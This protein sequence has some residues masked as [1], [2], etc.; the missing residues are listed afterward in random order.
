MARDKSKDDTLFNCAQQYEHDYVVGL[1]NLGQR[2]FVRTFL[3]N[4]CASNTIYHS[5]HFQV[6]QL[7]QKNLGY[8][9]PA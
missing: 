3:K 4:G 2:P 1:Y 7:I 8:S 6:Y 5:T 9:I